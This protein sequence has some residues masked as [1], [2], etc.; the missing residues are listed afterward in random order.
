MAIPQF[1][2]DSQGSW[3]GTSKLNLPWLPKDK[4]VSA[5]DSKFHIEID[6]RQKY[7]TIHYVWAYNGKRE[8]G[9]MLVCGDK[10]ESVEIGWSDSWHMNS[11]VM[12]LKGKHEPNSLKTLGSYTAEGQTW[13]WSIAF[14]LKDDV[15][16]MK[17]ENL[18][19][20]MDPQWAVEAEYRRE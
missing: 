12:Q 19:T 9:T 5:C 14:E 4:Q 7:A 11:G 13:G 2:Q 6:P 20:G 10:K 8:E 15:L 1:I 3:K 17:M 16:W 18:P